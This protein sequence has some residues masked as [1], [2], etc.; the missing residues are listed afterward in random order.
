MQR[1]QPYFPVLC[2]TQ[3]SNIA[4]NFKAKEGRKHDRKVSSIANTVEE[5]EKLLRENLQSVY[6]LED[7]VE[8][9]SVNVGIMA[10]NDTHLLM[11]ILKSFNLGECVYLLVYGKNYLQKND[12]KSVCYV[13]VQSIFESLSTYKITDY[14]FSF[15]G[16][17]IKSHS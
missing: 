9:T 7:C 12:D 4:A 13:T 16:K 17:G 5:S 2:L 15:G 3:I 1:K 11:E 6:V 10:Q 8:L 14:L